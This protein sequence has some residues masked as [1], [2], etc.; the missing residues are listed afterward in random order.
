MG[1]EKPSFIENSKQALKYAAIGFGVI[2]L[3]V[4]ALPAAAAQAAPAIQGSVVGTRTALAEALPGG[5]LEAAPA[6]ERLAALKTQ[7]APLA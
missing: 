4:L 7:I 5:I 3:G 2:G 6:A 1:L